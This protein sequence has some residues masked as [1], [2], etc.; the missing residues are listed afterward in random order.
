MNAVKQGVIISIFAALFLLQSATQLLPMHGFSSAENSQSRV[1][2]AVPLSVDE[3]TASMSSHH[4]D[5]HSMMSENCESHCQTLSQ[6][7]AELMCSNVVFDEFDKPALTF[8]PMQ[9]VN[10]YS[11]SDY[12]GFSSQSLYR[13]PI[14]SLS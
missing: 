7:C 14:S 12:I 6:D 4:P 5:T 10:F 8:A 1:L 11:L 9:S 13:P 2:S 3:N